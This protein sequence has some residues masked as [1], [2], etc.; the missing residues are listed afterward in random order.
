MAGKIRIDRWIRIGLLV[1][2]IGCNGWLDAQDQPAHYEFHHI[3]EKDG[4]SVN[5]INCFLQDRDGFL[6]VGTYDG[7]NRYDGN[8]F[9]QFKHK[10]MDSHSLLNNTVHDL[11]E[12]QQGNI[13]MA[14]EEGISRY[15][16]KTGK[17]TNITTVNT[18]ALGLCNNILCDR[19]GDIWFTSSRIGL[20]Q[21][22]IQTGQFKYF[23]Y[24]STSNPLTTSS[25][26][27]NNGLLEDPSH[28]GLWVA[29]GYG[30]H[31]FDRNRR[32]FLNHRNNPQRL[33]IFT[34]HYVSAL[35]LDG[36]RLIF[37][38]NDAHQIIMYSLS[39]QQILKTITPISRQ[40]NRAVFD[41]ATIFVDRKHNLWTSSWN[42]LLFHIAAESGE[43][44]ELEHDKSRPTSVAGAFFWSAWQHPDGS[45]WLGTVNGISYTNPERAF[46]SVYDI[47]SLFPPL[48]DERGI[49]CLVEDTDGSWWIG[50]SMRG[51]LHYSPQT[52][53][54]DVYKLPNA[55]AEHPYGKVLSS[56]SIA[57][58]MLYLA[59]ETNLF[60]FNKVNKTFSSLPLPAPIRQR[61][62]RLWNIL[63]DGHYLWA[64]GESTW[65]FRYHIPTRQWES[66][67]TL[68]ANTQ[69]SYMLSYLFKDRKQGTWVDLY[70]GG[71]ARFSTQQK[72]FI[73]DEH[74]RDKQYLNKVSSFAEDSA[75]NFWMSTNGYGLV[76]YNPRTHRY[77]NWTES[78]GLAYDHS[79]AALPDRFG[80]IWV[81]SYN[82]FS[83]FAPQTNRFLNFSLPYSP[84]NLEYINHLIPLRNGHILGSLKGYL[85][86][87]SPE[88]LVK[89]PAYLPAKI[90]I[91][92]VNVGDTIWLN[93]RDLAGVS[94]KAGE[95]AFAVHFGTLTSASEPT[96]DYVYQLDG[97]DEDWKPA[98]DARYAVY[99]RLPG[100]DYTFRVKAVLAD[101]RSIPAST[102]A[103]HIDT[104]L[105]QKRWFQAL[106]AFV[107]FGL[108][109]GFLRYRAHQRDRLHDLQVQA[110]RLERDKT[111][112]QYQNLINHLNPHFLFNSLTSLNSLINSSPPQASDFLR[113]LSIIY[114]YILQNKDNE[115]VTLESELSFVQN[116]IDLQIARF[117]K[118]LQIQVNVPEN[119]R[120]QRIV[121]VT[122]QN[123]LENAI[124]HNVIEEENPL[125]IRIYAEGSSLFVVN[126]LQKKSFVAT[127]N[128]QGLASLKSLY[129]YLSRRQIEVQE[130]A[131]QFVVKVPLL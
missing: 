39:N 92:Q 8:Q 71:I 63:K 43:I 36:D 50:T 127:S 110:S 95:S 7:V 46:Y 16:K 29:D 64:T 79:L 4:L 10:R 87:F 34:R 54:L 35:A 129:Q 78:E 115:L 128:K 32:Q 59:G 122:I 52:A 120:T 82:K 123:L 108:V 98:A 90:L 57:G 51:L 49:H 107:V 91:S 55:T 2:L 76:R 84:D 86:E 118:D 81:G 60:T 44:T 69:R 20:F 11:C 74:T 85:V 67:P 53:R 121:P 40:S 77:A 61:K 30:L 27:S 83:V 19:T 113:K 21:Y 100:G 31:Y 45:I 116:Y 131:T 68:P 106:L 111:E 130:T 33:P 41:I 72:A 42:H 102:L 1:W 14:V 38:D 15:D 109:I 73:V 97:Y 56:L 26:V 13:W 114:R 24:D 105:Y 117:Q 3:Q 124:K 12:D 62:A 28:N 94:L 70:P 5:I 103:I 126:N 96:F 89:Q 6:W 22:T 88:K 80:N 99:T 23:P 112:I 17:F 25:Y 93:H 125:V 47:G 104:Y 119:Y 75:G 66:Y 18:R 48:N 101:G 37:A 65:V 58:D 9:V